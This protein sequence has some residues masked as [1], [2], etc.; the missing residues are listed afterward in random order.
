MPTDDHRILVTIDI[1]GSHDPDY[2]PGGPKA[3][4]LTFPESC[5]CTFNLVSVP[6]NTT[7]ETAEDICAE[8][9]AT[10]PDFVARYATERESMS[11]HICGS[12]LKDFDITPGEALILRTRAAS[13]QPDVYR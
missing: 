6:Y 11:V 4:A 9:G 3:I 12:S 8:L 2:F 1:V 10:A 5:R 13:W 7:A